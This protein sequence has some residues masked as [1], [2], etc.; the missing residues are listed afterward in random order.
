MTQPEKSALLYPGFLDLIDVSAFQGK[1]DFNKVKAAGFAGVIVKVSEGLSSSDAQAL[2]NLKASQDA[3]LETMV[4]AFARPDQGRA[5]DQ[6]D[7]LYSAAG[8]TMPHRVA[9]DLET[10]PAGWTAAQKVDFGEQFVEAC[11]KYSPLPPMLYTFPNFS[12]GMQPALSGSTVL[13]ACPLWIAHYMSTT[14]PWAPPQ[15]FQPYTPKPFTTWALHQY[16]GDNGFGGAGVVGS[17]DRNLFKGDVACFRQFLGLSQD[18]SVPVITQTE[19]AVA[20]SEATAGT[21]VNLDPPADLS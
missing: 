7:K 21:D 20:T 13:A 11:L 19:T 18:Q 14:S 5:A 1:P 2:Y 6:V 17:C 12:Q 8:A 9:M 16:S 3:G 10:A 4:Y 15:G